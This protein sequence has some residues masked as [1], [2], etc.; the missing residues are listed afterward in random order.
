[1]YMQLAVTP[2]SF[3]PGK[4]ISFEIFFI[5]ILMV[6]Y[7]NFHNKERQRERGAWLHG[8]APMPLLP[9]FFEKYSYQQ[10]KI[11]DYLE[12]YIFFT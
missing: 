10:R 9:R 4:D 2:I 3:F 7:E 5:K 11:F 1:M 6:K 8:M 12:I